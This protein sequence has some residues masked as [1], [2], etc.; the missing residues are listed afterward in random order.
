MTE[1]GQ[2]ESNLFS[3]GSSSEYFILLLF[4]GIGKKITQADLELAFSAS[5]EA[6]YSFQGIQIKIRPETARLNETKWLFCLIRAEIL[7]Y[8]HAGASQS[9]FRGS[10]FGCQLN[11]TFFCC[12]LN[13]TGLPGV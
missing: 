6:F 13:S 8:I 10:C 11:V 2:V 5:K 7:L 1:A 9:V 3:T 4:F 12:V